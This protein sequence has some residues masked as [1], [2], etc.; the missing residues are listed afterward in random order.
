M[1]IAIVQHH[2]IPNFMPGIGLHPTADQSQF[3]PGKVLKKS[4][5]EIPEIPSFSI[6]NFS[7]FA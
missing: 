5:I 4:K 3:E 2:T 7:F 1:A 6:S